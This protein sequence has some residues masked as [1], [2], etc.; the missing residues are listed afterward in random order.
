MTKDVSE[1]SFQELEEHVRIAMPLVP[2]LGRDLSSRIALLLGLIGALAV[3]LVHLVPASLQ[4]RILYVGLVL[5]FLGF[6]LYVVRELASEARWLRDPRMNFAADLEDDFRRHNELLAWLR[7]QP[8]NTLRARALYLSDRRVR[9]S[10]RLSVIFG[11]ID[12]LGILPLLA[13]AYLQL[14]GGVTP[15]GI[16]MWEGVAALLLLGTYAI[17]HL[18]LRLQRQVELYIALFDSALVGEGEA[19][20]MTR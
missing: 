15:T 10:N 17:A 18:G 11:G 13:A 14:K 20:R 8:Q 3:A 5:E 9:L 4:L 6:G 19:G 2:V 12:K 7:A 16:S 1:F